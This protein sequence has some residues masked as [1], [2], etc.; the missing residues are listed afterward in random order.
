MSA[1][2]WKDVCEKA[3]RDTEGLP[4]VFVSSSQDM[5]RH[6]GPC[7]LVGAVLEAN[8]D[9]DEESLPIYRVELPDGTRI[10]AFEEELCSEDT[11]G[12]GRLIDGV[13]MTFGLD[14]VLGDWAGPAHLMASAN[15][16]IRNRFLELLRA[17]PAEK[18]K[19]LI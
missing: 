1:M 12:L 17:S 11:G 16:E 5:S 10:D 6:E 2:T 18:A 19:A 14:R 7:K 4:L 13:S 3:I 8:E 15:E 9:Y